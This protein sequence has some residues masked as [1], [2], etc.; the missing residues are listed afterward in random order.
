MDPK[1]RALLAAGAAVAATTAVPRVFAQ[2]S[3]S[4][5][6][7]KFSVE[8]T[9]GPNSL[10]GP[11]DSFVPPRASACL[12]SVRRREGILRRNERRRP[13]PVMSVAAPGT[14]LPPGSP[15]ARSSSPHTRRFH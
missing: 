3:G 13:K 4:R 5:G 14:V 10:G 7:G 6:T 15:G 8:R 12:D 2:Q 11:T 9:Q 1:R